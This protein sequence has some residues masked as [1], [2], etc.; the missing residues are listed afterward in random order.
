MSLNQG[1][2]KYRELTSKSKQAAQKAKEEK[3]AGH[4]KSR[5]DLLPLATATQYCLTG[6]E[7]VKNFE[8]PASGGGWTCWV[9]AEDSAGLWVAKIPGPVRWQIG[10]SNGTDLPVIDDAPGLI[11]NL[12][13]QV[14]SGVKATRIRFWATPTPGR[15][16]R[17]EFQ[18]KP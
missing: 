12:G 4:E 6:G 8:I 18:A 15:V 10:L 2:Q 13:N 7:P 1:I 17:V 9:V 3:Y 14:P 16:V 5:A 11:F